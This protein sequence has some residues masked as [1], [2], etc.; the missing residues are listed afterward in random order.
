MAA[1]V[2]DELKR[3]RAVM[4]DDGVR[5]AFKRQ[6]AAGHS[7]AAVTCG[8]HKV[9]VWGSALDGFIG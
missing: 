6:I 9:R 3:R 4:T 8:D 5:E 7:H 1:G 2:R